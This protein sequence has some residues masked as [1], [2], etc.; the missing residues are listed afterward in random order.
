MDHYPLLLALKTKPVL[1]T[2][3]VKHAQF[4]YPMAVRRKKC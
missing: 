3:Q 1:G 4:F 2:D